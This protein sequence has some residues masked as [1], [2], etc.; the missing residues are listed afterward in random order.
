VRF[1]IRQ[2]KSQLARASRHMRRRRVRREIDH[3]FATGEE[4]QSEA[5]QAYLQVL[6]AFQRM[7]DQSIG[8][9]G[10]Q[11]ARQE[12]EQARDRFVVSL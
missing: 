7:N 8:G 3:F 12:Y 9:D 6:R 10:Y 11:Q 4:P 2:F 5:G 1:Q